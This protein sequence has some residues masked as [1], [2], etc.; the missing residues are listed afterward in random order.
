MKKTDINANNPRIR[1]FIIII[2]IVFI[3]ILYPLL[4][5]IKNSENELKTRHK[6]RKNIN[7]I[8]TKSKK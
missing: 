6:A 5:P 7:N 3:G 1:Q 2:D 4:S 8:L